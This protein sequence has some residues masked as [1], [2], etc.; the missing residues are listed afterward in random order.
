MILA[1]FSNERFM[2]RKI[3][4]QVVVLDRG[5]LLAGAGGGEYFFR[6]GPGPGSDRGL[7][8]LV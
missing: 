4:Y 6:P 8:D 5:R 3:L 2:A 7:L 1:L